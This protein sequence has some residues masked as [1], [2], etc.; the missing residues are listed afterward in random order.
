MANIGIEIEHII[1][2]RNGTDH[3]LTAVEVPHSKARPYWI[4]NAGNI[5][6]DCVAA[7]IAIEPASNAIECWK[8]YSELRSVLLT[9]FLDPLDLWI[10]TGSQGTFSSESLLASPEANEIGCSASFS[11]YRQ[12]GRR[13][14]TP[15][16]Y[17]SNVRHTGI[18]LN[19][20]FDGTVREKRAFIRTLDGFVGLHSV[21]FWEQDTAV[22]SRLRRGF[23]GQA[24]NHRLK[25]FGVEYR[26]LPASVWNLQNLKEIYRLV[27]LALE[28]PFKYRDYDF[29]H[30]INNCIKVL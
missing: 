5:Q 19:I 25:D 1:K 14:Q 2:N 17:T 28:D 22:E 10:A 24:G 12:D 7:E 29:R 18:H 30:P 8:K 23:Y 11:A 20:D 3:V 6:L 15:S 9:T 16:E 4:S 27:E 21:S 13:S 26:T